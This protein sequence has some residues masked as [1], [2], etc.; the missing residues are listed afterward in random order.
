MSKKI[1]I[2]LYLS[3]I[4]YSALATYPTTA[5]DHFFY[6]PDFKSNYTW[7]TPEI[8][9]AATYWSKYYHVPISDI[10]AIIHHE[11]EGNPYARSY[12]NARGL[13]QVM[14]YHW[15]G[16]INQLYDINLNIQ[17][18]TRYYRWCLDYCKNDKSCAIRCY[19]A[20]PYYPQSNY[21]NYNY[22]YGI[23]NKSKGTA[24]ILSKP[25]LVY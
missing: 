18:G 9:L 24:P 22:L 4:L 25:I 21:K 5:Y 10:L 23:L 15:S 19:N 7:L 20:G 16:D 12:T 11:S 14:P 17:L 1:R 8:Y 6:Y 3:A 13:M 2:Y